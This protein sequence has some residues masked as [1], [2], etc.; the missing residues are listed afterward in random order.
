MVAGGFLNYTLWHT[1]LEQGSCASSTQR[2]VIVQTG[3]PTSMHM[4]LTILDKVFLPTATESYQGPCT[5]AV[6]FG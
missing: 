2:V 6:D 4:L 3:I 1:C 5:G